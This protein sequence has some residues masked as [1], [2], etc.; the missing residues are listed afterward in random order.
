MGRWVSILAARG[1]FLG[2]IQE[3]GNPQEGGKYG[4]ELLREREETEP[5][6]ATAR[7]STFTTLPASYDP[8]ISSPT[9][10]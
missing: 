2:K 7:V 4:F 5:G 9:L 6:L 8:V 10:C 1:P 3:Q